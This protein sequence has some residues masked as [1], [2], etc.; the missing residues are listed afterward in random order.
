MMNTQDH[1]HPKYPLLHVIARLLKRVPWW[2]LLVVVVVTAVFFWRILFFGEHIAFRDGAHFYPPL[3]E[4]IQSEWRAGRIP[5]WNPYEN[6][7]QPLLAN[8]VSSVFYPGKL[9][10]FLPITTYHAYH[11][12]VIGHFLLAALTCYRLAQRFNGSRPAAMIAT[13]SYVFG[14]SVLFQYSN[15]VFLVGA[16]WLPEAIRQADIMITT[17]RISSVIALGLVFA[18]FVLGGDPQMAY[19]A[20]VVILLLM[21]F[22]RRKNKKSLAD[23]RFSITTHSVL[24]LIESNTSSSSGAFLVS[25]AGRSSFWSRPIF[26]LGFALLTGA[27][28]AAVQWLPSLELGA[29]GDRKL[30]DHPVSLWRS[31]AVLERGYRDHEP[32]QA[33]DQVKEGLVAKETQQSSGMARVRYNFSVGPWRLIELIWP[34]ANGRMFPIHTNWGM[35]IAKKWPC[36]GI[37]SPSLYMGII[38]FL[39]A[40]IA[41][42]FRKASPLTLWLSW[43]FLIFLLGS[44]GYFGLGWGINQTIALLGIR[45]H[46][47][48]VGGPFGGVYWLFSLLLPGYDQFRYPAKLLTVTALMLSL[49]AARSFDAVFGIPDTSEPMH[50]TDIRQ[51]QR[52]FRKN[53]LGL[54]RLL[55]VLSFLLIPAVL[56][57]RNWVILAKHVPNDLVFGSFMA[58]RALGEA[59]FSL[60]H[61]LNILFVFFAITRIFSRKLLLLERSDNPVSL[62]EQSRK[63]EKYFYRLGF[64]VVILVSFDLVLSNHW[65]IGTAPRHFFDGKPLMATFLGVQE[66]LTH[67]Q[68]EVTGG[69]SNDTASFPVRTWRSPTYS[70]PFGSEDGSQN[71]WPKEFAN[72]SPNRL[73]EWVIWER[74]SLSPRYPLLQHVAVTD[75]RGTVVSADYYAISHIMRDAWQSR[76]IPQRDG[77]FSL[78]EYLESL[79][80]SS[81]IVPANRKKEDYISEKQLYDLRMTD[82]VELLDQ[83][84]REE[85]ESNQL[86]NEIGQLFQWGRNQKSITQLLPYEVNYWP[87]NAGPRITLSDRIQLEQPIGFCSRDI[88]FEKSR[89]ILMHNQQTDIPIVEWEKENFDHLPIRFARAFTSMAAL[90][91]LPPHSQHPDFRHPDFGASFPLGEMKP[92]GETELVFYEP[93]KIVVRAV[94]LRPGWLTLSDQYDTNWQAEVRPISEENRQLG[95]RPPTWRVPILRTN[96]VLRGIPLPEGEWEVTF[97][98]NPLSFRLGATFSFFAWAALVM[99]LLGTTAKKIRRSKGFMSNKR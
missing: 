44:F 50:L 58:D 76:G 74:A 67:P 45:P 35:A 73:T 3:F 61:V 22:H 98:Y 62:S 66:S 31:I 41:L 40:M 92:V 39:L 32:H 23:S 42:R 60:V 84:A 9:V 38:P 10:Y 16:A 24:N 87:L 28:L 6:L 81:M 52:K 7:G 5:L 36:S 80:N 94:V 11:L 48:G 95:D 53:L 34:N 57:P 18:M 78:S 17:R 79:G 21:F 8:P 51:K 70:R 64:A 68:P 46:P 12:Y 75:T 99:F 77:R 15:I 89:L 90:G 19:H 30:E 55:I 27:S 54:T 97:V 69:Y 72:P 65:M 91:E 96:R 71:W 29:N 26:L 93:Q 25:G 49:L 2:C 63:H 37:W 85:A 20:L 33:W 14:G 1:H 88:F 82:P 83:A 59:A 13:L 47:T 4:Y 56:F 43:S 86:P